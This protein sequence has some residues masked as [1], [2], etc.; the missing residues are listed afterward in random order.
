[1]GFILLQLRFSAQRIAWSEALETAEA[2][3]NYYKWC[4]NN[5][6]ADQCQTEKDYLGPDGNAI[7]KFSLQVDS[8]AYCGELVQRRIVSTGWTKDYSQTKRKIKVLYARTSVAKYSYVVSDNVWVGS[9]HIIRGPYHSNGGIRMDGENQSLVTSAAPDGKWICTESFG[10]GPAGM[11]SRGLGL[12]HCPDVCDIDAN[13]NCVCP[14][15]S[16]PLITA[17]RTCSVFR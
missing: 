7:G 5:E 11:A 6:V 4:L 2:G 12:G 17:T 9:D 14:E 1:M 3:I 10:C 13:K 8:T 16:P 15:F